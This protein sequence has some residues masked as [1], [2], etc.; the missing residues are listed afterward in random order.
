MPRLNVWL[1]RL[2]VPFLWAAGGLIL[3]AMVLSHIA[4]LNV[5]ANSFYLAAFV[6]SG[7]PV[8]LRA[9]QALR[10]I[11][12]FAKY[13]TPAVAVLA[14][15]YAQLNEV[16]AKEIFQQLR[17]ENRLRECPERLIEEAKRCGSTDN[18]TVVIAA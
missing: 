14:A 13:D 10:F 18:I 11:D 3:A 4:G 15:L 7:V 1:K 2:S 6:P 12:R 8:L 9:V 5:L 17:Q 16:P